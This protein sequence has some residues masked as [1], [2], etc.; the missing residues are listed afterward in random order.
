VYNVVATNVGAAPTDGS[1]ITITDDLPSG[2]TLDSHGVYFQDA[3]LDPTSCSEGSTIVCTAP[4]PLQP[5]ETMV[6]RIPVDVA[7]DAPSSV[8]DTATISGGAAAAAQAADLTTIS[9]T[10]ASPG[11]HSFQGLLTGE[12]GSP[13]MQAGSHPFSMMFSFTA[14]SKTDAAGNTVPDDNIKDVQAELP[15]GM[16]GYTN[17]VPFCPVQA[18][19]TTEGTD[20]PSDSA[21]GI[22]RFQIRLTP[23]AGEPPVI[24]WEPIWNL[25]P[26]AGVPAEFGIRPAG[27]FSNLGVVMQ[28]RLRTGGDYGIT[29]DTP[30]VPENASLYAATLTFWGVPAD[31]RHD[32]LRGHCLQ[33]GQDGGGSSGTCPAGVTPKPLL[34]LPTSC[35]GVLSSTIRI[36]SWEEPGIWHA[37]SST[38]GDLAGLGGCEALSF[39]PS[40]EVVP[41]TSAT[42]SP[43]SLNFGLDIPQ[44]ENSTSLASANLE[45]TTVA[46]PT[47]MVVSPSAANGL[48]TCSPGEIGLNNAGTPSCPEASRVGTAEAISPS[49]QTPLHGA[50][51]I[52]QQGNNPFGSL[53]ALYVALEGSGVLVKVAGN[54]HLDPTTGQVTTTFNDMPQQ[55]VSD[56]KLQLFGGRRAPLVTPPG[57]GT[58]TTT[59][60]LGPWSA[61]FTPFAT[62]SSAFEITQGCAAPGFSPPFS[63]GTTDNQ[64]G[65]F[66]AFTT[67]ISRSDQ[68]QNLSVLQIRTPSGLLGMLSKVPLCDE[69]QANVGTCPKASQI[70]HVTVQ[71]GVGSQPITLPEADKQ[72]DPVYLTSP[73]NGG[74]FGLSIVVHP[75]AGPFNL[76]EGGHPV[77][78][79]ASIAVNPHT[80]AITVTSD[81]MPTI[82]QGIPLDVRSVAVTIDREGFMFNATNCQPLAIEGTLQSAQGATAV[83]SSHYEAA[84]CATLP[85]KPKFSASTT[86]KASKTGGASLDVKVFAKGGPQAGGGEANIKSVKVDLPKQLPSRL[87]TLQKACTAKVFEANPASCPKESNVGMATAATPVLAHPLIGPAYLVSHGGE[88]F[89]DLEIVLQGEGITL[90]LD[91]NTEI[92][93]GITSSTF[94]SVPDAPISSF[95]L[96]LPTGKFSILG[97]NVPQKAK[98]NLCG[99]TLAMP[100]AITGQNGAVIKQSTN[101]TISGCPKHALH[102]NPPR[103]LGPKKRSQRKVGR[104]RH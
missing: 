71:A 36:D 34:T 28:A 20:C 83:V 101:I 4:G 37:M 79:R 16:I 95:E 60:E 96:K 64:S 69:A 26:P 44:N 54:V 2:F 27:A 5:G 29:V 56:I 80:S 39:E 21:V 53:L 103:F 38:L 43:T 74:P 68:E 91:G 81:P 47:G 90:I 31:P 17:A 84:N 99:Q 85:F 102:R 14:N 89:P 40:I 1:M 78:V 24:D 33:E 41:Q 58:Y 55:A 77:I 8:T 35:V 75:E 25:Q 45:N 12:D 97:A 57:C 65:A 10:A 30:E 82:L 18:F 104:S 3:T 15:Q 66:S 98:Y 86:G 70:G 59:S 94:K 61:P 42:S 46:L 11:L 52:A 32:V 6:L 73:Y 51:Y 9:A 72:E 49:L 22:A 7:A 87:T 67:M 93:K 88:A 63:A 48:E 13:A 62:P 50:I 100:T 92:K 76:E 23:T 19:Y